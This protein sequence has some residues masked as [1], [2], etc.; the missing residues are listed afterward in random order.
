MVSEKKTLCISLKKINHD[1]V[2][3]AAIY[4]SGLNDLMRLSE[5]LKT[6]KANILVII[7]AC[8]KYTNQTTY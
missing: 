7:K 8:G 4:Q 5:K 3:V 6:Y 2:C 1:D